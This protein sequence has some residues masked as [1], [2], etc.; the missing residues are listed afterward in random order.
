MNTLKPL[1]KISIIYAL[2]YI[3]DGKESLLFAQDIDVNVKKSQNII[4]FL[5]S[6]YS[7]INGLAIGIIGSET[8]CDYKI[9]KISNGLNLQIGQGLFILPIL[10]YDI[11]YLNHKSKVFVD[12]LILNQDTA[13]YKAKH[14]GLLISMFG[15]ATDRINGVTISSIFSLHKKTNGLSVSALGNLIYTMNGIS[16]SIIN[17]TVKTRGIQIG[18]YNSATELNGVQ[19]GLINRSKNRFMPLIN[20]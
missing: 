6:K 19:I 11:S 5:P 8:Y 10:F 1:I 20:F 12:S 2:I 9:S 7:K 17:K 18:L 3:F 13:Y 16:I 14:N 15:S 4:G